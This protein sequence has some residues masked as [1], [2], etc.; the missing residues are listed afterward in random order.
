MVNP[1]ILWVIKQNDK[2]TMI[3]GGITMIKRFFAMF[4]GKKI[5][6]HNGVVWLNTAGYM[7]Y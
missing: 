5:Y 1:R 6:V 2:I 7:D 4:T 3:Y